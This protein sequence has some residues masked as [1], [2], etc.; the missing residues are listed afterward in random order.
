MIIRVA[1]MVITVDRVVPGVHG[2]QKNVRQRLIAVGRIRVGIIERSARTDRNRV[3]IVRQLL[4]V[5]PVAGVANLQHRVSGEGALDIEAGVL[6]AIP[7]NGGRWPHVQGGGTEYQAV[8]AGCDPRKRGEVHLWGVSIR[9]LP[10]QVIYLVPVETVIEDAETA[11]Q[12]CFAV[13]GK[14]IGKAE[15]RREGE[16]R[17]VV[18]RQR[19]TVQTEQ[20]QAIGGSSPG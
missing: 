10:R 3:D 5:T 9:R 17:L 14:V 7:R 13:T 16:R 19:H 15:A 4:V 11:A 2:S 1:Q 18:W 12:S 8:A 6:G 20:L